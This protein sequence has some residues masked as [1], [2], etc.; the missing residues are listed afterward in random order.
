M[1]SVLQ[2]VSG[3]FCCNVYEQR[4]VESW[5]SLN[6]WLLCFWSKEFIFSKSKS[7]F[8]WMHWTN[9]LDWEFWMFFT[10]KVLGLL[11]I[12]GL[13]LR[14]WQINVC[15]NWHKRTNN[16]LWFT[17]LSG[18]SNLS[19]STLFSLISSFWVPLFHILLVF[20]PW[21]PTL[22]FHWIAKNLFSWIIFLVC[23]DQRKLPF[24][25]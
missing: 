7:Q 20:S 11:N 5:N 24:L 15:L 6:H 22:N 19:N 9:M 25:D 14:I 17:K 2:L 10:S 8:F 23:L 13:F 3:W 12:S 4:N 1:S 21:C 16:H 18:G